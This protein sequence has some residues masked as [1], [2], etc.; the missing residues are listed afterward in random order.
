MMASQTVLELIA[1]SNVPR[2]TS[3]RCA[4]SIQRC[5]RVTF[6][7]VHMDRF[8]NMCKAIARKSA[9]VTRW[10]GLPFPFFFLEAVGGALSDA[11]LSGALASVFSSSSDGCES[12]SPSHAGSSA[13]LR[14]TSAVLDTEGWVGGYARLRPSMNSLSGSCG[15]LSQCF[16]HASASW[17]GA[18]A[19]G[20]GISLIVN[21]VM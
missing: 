20:R 11:C 2:R 8:S 18:Y 13:V 19:V 4:N 9:S 1:R 15:C 16:F 10:C 17:C 5:T 3:L 6:K 7:S 14:G 21:I 12:L